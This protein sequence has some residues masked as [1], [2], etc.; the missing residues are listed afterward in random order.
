MFVLKAH[1]GSHIGNNA[2]SEEQKSMNLC[3]RCF[4]IPSKDQNAAKSV[5]NGYNKCKES[6]INSG[7]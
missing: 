1:A 4:L 3:K 5:V 7:W 6:E 2:R